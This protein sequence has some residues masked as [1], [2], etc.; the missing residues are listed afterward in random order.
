[1]D[2]KSIKQIKG[3]R[4]ISQIG[5]ATAGGNAIAA[6]FWIYMADDVRIFR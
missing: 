3:L 5:A 2:W 4:S 1:M 6:L